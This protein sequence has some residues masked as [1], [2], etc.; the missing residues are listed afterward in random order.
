VTLQPMTNLSVRLPV[1]QWERL[2][3]LAKR[4]NITKGDGNPN[5]SKAAVVALAAGLRA[6]DAG[7]AALE[8]GDNRQEVNR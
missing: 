1:K 6:L 8:V 3:K 7:L 2:A 4:K 5:L